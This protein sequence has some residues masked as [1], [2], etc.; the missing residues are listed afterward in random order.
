MKKIKIIFVAL[1]LFFVL[2]VTLGAAPPRPAVNQ[3]GTGG[4]DVWFHGIN[5]TH[6][7][8]T[9]LTFFRLEVPLREIREE[10]RHAFNGNLSQQL[11]DLN[12]EFFRE[13]LSNLTLDVTLIIRFPNLI[14]SS[15]PNETVFVTTSARIRLQPHS[16]TNNLNPLRISY[17]REFEFLTNPSISLSNNFYAYLSRMDNPD[18]SGAYITVQ[19]TVNDRRGQHLVRH[20]VRQTALSN[21][22]R[23]HRYDI[24]NIRL[25]QITL[26]AS[27]VDPNS[28]NFNIDEGNTGTN[29]FPPALEGGGVGG[30]GFGMSGI[31]S[32]VLNSIASAFGISTDEFMSILIIG[33]VILAVVI[34]AAIILPIVLKK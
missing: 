32:R 1:T 13:G 8:I 19:H 9:Q 29:L 14:I 6:F 10:T 7:G 31:L 26:D 11:N 28:P 22:L 34:A 15:R 25:R 21:D 20:D 17:A 27:V 18:F 33:G 3:N 4:G 12:F 30:G 16:W 2:G 5:L 23:H 24:P